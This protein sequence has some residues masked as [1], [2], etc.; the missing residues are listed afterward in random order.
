MN[1]H[2]ESTLPETEA[3]MFENLH[4]LLDHLIT[5]GDTQIDDTFRHQ[6]GNIGRIREDDAGSRIRAD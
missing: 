3:A 4:A 5:A 1:G 6:N 2:R